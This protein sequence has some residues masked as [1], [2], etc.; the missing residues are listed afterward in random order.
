[1]KKLL[2]YFLTIFTSFNV[3]AQFY[4]GVDQA[5]GKNRVQYKQEWIWSYFSYERF[6]VY[7][8]R[9]GRNL[10]KNVS[11]IT[12][13]CFAEVEKELEYQ[14]S[15]RIEILAYNSFDDFK[16]ANVSAL[17]PETLTIT[18]NVLQSTVFGNEY[19]LTTFT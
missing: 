7:F 10:A 1:M 18:T 12:S 15:D 11:A 16:T 13:E 9:D 5:F 17:F 2:F 4:N 19:P 8:Y 3:T 14:I 6:D